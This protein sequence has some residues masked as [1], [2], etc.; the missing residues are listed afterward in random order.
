MFTRQDLRRTAGDLR[1]AGTGLLD[2]RRCYGSKLVLLIGLAYPF[3]PI[4]LIP[5]RLPVIGYLDQVAFVIGG[6]ALAYLLLPPPYRVARTAAGNRSVGLPAQRQSR[7]RVSLAA[8]TRALVLESFAGALAVPMLRLATGAWP[9]EVDVRAFRRAF[10]NFTPLPPLLRGLVTVPAAREQLTRAMLSG[11]LLADESYRRAVRAEFHGDDPRPGDALRVW[12]GQ[13]VT[14]LHLEKT[15]GMSMIA[16]LSA[17]FHPLQIDADPR[18]AFPPHVLTPLP[19]FLL[20]RVRRCKLVWGHYDLPSI[21]RLGAYRFT[22]T[23]LREPRARIRSL[24]RYWRGQ[25]ALDLG[26]NGMNQPVLAAQ[27]LDFADFLATDDCMVLNYI[28]NFYVRRLIG[29][30]AMPG[31]PDPLAED[32]QACLAAALEALASLDFV[33]LSVHADLSLARLGKK[34]DFVPPPTTPR[35]NATRQTAPQDA[36]SFAVDASLSHLTRL[37]RVIYDTAAARFMSGG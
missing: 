12:A 2:P 9:S 8:R 10:R 25:A 37:D 33:G 26:W 36:E 18:R 31:E 13:P 6:I 24:Y 17:Q 11:W 16:V 20:D 3:G 21:R 28:D 23:M 22:F 5:N 29:A 1:L 7:A 27:R 32:P 4:D 14:F 35:I 19:P 30:Y 15:G 34:L